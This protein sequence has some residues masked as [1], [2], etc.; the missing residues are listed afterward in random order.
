MTWAVWLGRLL[1]WRLWRRSSGTTLPA[2][3]PAPTVASKT[4]A[5]KPLRGRKSRGL[6]MSLMLPT[7]ICSACTTLPERPEASKGRPCYQWV[8]TKDQ[9][10]YVYEYGHMVARLE[11]EPYDAVISGWCVMRNNEHFM[12]DIRRL[13]Q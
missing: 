13:S 6:L 2:N 4:P 8:F 5:K 7:L 9:E 10:A 11:T 3:K 12:N 1:Q